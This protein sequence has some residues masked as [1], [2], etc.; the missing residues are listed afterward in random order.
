MLRMVPLPGKCRGGERFRQAASAAGDKEKTCSHTT[1]NAFVLV[2]FLSCDS[3]G[4]VNGATRESPSQAGRATR[5]LTTRD[6]ASGPAAAIGRSA[7]GRP[8]TSV[9]KVRIS[10]TTR[11]SAGR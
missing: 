6:M 11:L 10:A 5:E 7:G 8:S 3:G 2:L 9:R 4:R 1:H